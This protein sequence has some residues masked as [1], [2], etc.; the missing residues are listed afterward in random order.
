MQILKINDVPV[1]N[2]RDVV[3]AIDGCKTSFIRMELEYD[4][5]NTRSKI[6][7][8]CTLSGAERMG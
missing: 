1:S 4:Q 6:P 5:V 8:S 2:L 7:Q 3:A